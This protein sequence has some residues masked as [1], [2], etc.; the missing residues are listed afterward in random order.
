M[1]STALKQTIESCVDEYFAE[2]QLKKA[3]RAATFPKQDA[4]IED[5]SQFICAQCTRRAGKTTALAKKFYKTMMKYPGSLSR[6][7]ALTRDSAKDI[8]WGILQDMDEQE[9]WGAEFV[10]TTLTMVLPNGARL[11]LLGA[12]MKNFIRRLKGAKS[13]A[14]AIDEA[15]D[16]GSHL[17]SLID[18]VLTPTLVDYQDSWLALTGTPGPIPRG[19]FYDVSHRGIGGYSIHKWSLFENPYLPDAS[20]FVEALK[21]KKAWDDH[22]PTYLR[23]YQNKWVLDTESLLIK[24][25]REKNHYD[26]L[27]PLHWNYILGVDIG[28]KDADALAVIAWSEATPDIYLVEETLTNGQDISQLAFQIEDTMKR[29]D[30][31]KIVMDEGALGKKIGEELRRRKQLPITAADKARKMENVA[32]LNDYLRLGKFKAKKESRFAQDSYQVQIDHEKTTPDRLVVKKGFHSDIIDAV[33]YAFKESPSFTYT[34]PIIKPKY[35]TPEWAEAEI[36]EMERAAIDHFEKLEEA[37]YGFGM[38]G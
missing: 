27:P 5:P 18:D 32:F 14:V 11:R 10:E 7:I 13:P 19:V 33:L 37:Q 12:D 23:E 20:K 30:I 15:Q 8:M 4:F 17:E 28:H 26:A 3:G 22:N 9:E 34:P 6:Y 36:T 35:G 16:F 2:L 25:D 1:L 38:L 31:A 24:Y 29:Y 21:K